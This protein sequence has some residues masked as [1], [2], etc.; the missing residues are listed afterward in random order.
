MTAG[1]VDAVAV[2][3]CGLCHGA[4]ARAAAAA[5]AAWAGVILAPGRGRTQTVTQAAVI[6]HAVAASMRRVGVFVDPTAAEVLDAVRLLKLDA[7]QLHGDE[8]VG[9][10][11]QIRAGAGCEVWKAVRVRDP[12]D[13]V[14]GA[15]TWRGR[16]DALLLDGW[17]PDAHG[18]A[19]AR[20]DWAAAAAAG[21]PGD[22]RVIAAGG[23]TPE[24]VA[25][26]ISLLRPAIVDVSSGVESVPGRKSPD[27]IQAFVAA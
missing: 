8:A 24:N 26:A 27:R 5:G 2:K 7:V 4:D 21:L 12:S 9:L 11:K 13:V 15:R 3:I 20:F 17:S 19:G 22:M 25:G 14:T 23:L 10:V 16:V 18:G 6:F 1:A